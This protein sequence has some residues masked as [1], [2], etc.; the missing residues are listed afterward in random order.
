MEQGYSWPE[1]V[2]ARLRALGWSRGELARRAGVERPSVTRHLN[3]ARYLPGEGV[4]RRYAEV[5]GLDGERLIA[6]VHLRRPVGS[7]LRE[8]GVLMERVRV[9]EQGKGK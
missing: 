7:P 2:N 6:A 4:V 1:T 5:L 8:I 9:L 3:T